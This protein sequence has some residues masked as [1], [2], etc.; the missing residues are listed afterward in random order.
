MRL[1]LDSLLKTIICGLQLD[2][3][4]FTIIL[5]RNKITPDCFQ[6]I[7]LIQKYMPFK[8]PDYQINL[9]LTSEDS[10]IQP[11]TVLKSKNAGQEYNCASQR[12]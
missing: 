6:P 10:L 3:I 4:L 5:R 2:L 9:T 7:K 8:V 1:Q 12:M 11:E